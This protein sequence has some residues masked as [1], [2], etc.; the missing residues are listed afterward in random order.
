MSCDKVAGFC[1][2]LLQVMRGVGRQT[3]AS[4]INGACY[5]GIGLPLC[6]CAPAALSTGALAHLGCW[7]CDA[8][9]P[10]RGHKTAGTRVGGPCSQPAHRGEGYWCTVAGRPCEVTAAVS[11]ACWEAPPSWPAMSTAAACLQRGTALQQLSHCETG[12]QQVRHLWTV[13]QPHG[14]LPPA[15][16]ERHWYLGGSTP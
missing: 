6:T 14:A 4:V 11:P 9:G 13:H 2:A 3:I 8:A 12:H 10:L 5:W 7:L 1:A 16:P 15:S